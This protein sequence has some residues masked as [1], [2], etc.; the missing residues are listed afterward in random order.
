MLLLAPLSPLLRSPCTIVKNSLDKE[1]GSGCLTVSL[2]DSS[3]NFSKSLSLLGG[4]LLAFL[5]K[6]EAAIDP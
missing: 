4:S 6:V 3:T 5:K 1:V 2:N